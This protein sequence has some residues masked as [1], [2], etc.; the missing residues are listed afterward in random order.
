LKCIFISPLSNWPLIERLLSTKITSDDRLD[1]G[2]T[3]TKDRPGKV[4]ASLRVTAA[5]ASYF[6]TIGRQVG[7]MKRLNLLMGGKSAMQ[8]ILLCCFDEKAWDQ[9]PE[10]QRKTIMDDYRVRV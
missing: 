4:R 5:S 3:D 1:H 6:L 7:L 9:L 10:S 8:Y 2:N